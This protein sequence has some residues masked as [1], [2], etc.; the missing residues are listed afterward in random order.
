MQN[1]LHKLHDTLLFTL[2]LLV[3]GKTRMAPF[4]SFQSHPGTRL[5]RDYVRVANLFFR[6][7]EESFGS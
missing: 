7:Y 1:G 3:K 6:M 2:G 5:F 4:Y